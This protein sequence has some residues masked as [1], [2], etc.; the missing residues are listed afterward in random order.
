[1]TINLDVLGVFIKGWIA[2][3]KDGSL[4]I[5]IHEHDTMY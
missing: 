4:V 2:R 1:M 5:I 3:E